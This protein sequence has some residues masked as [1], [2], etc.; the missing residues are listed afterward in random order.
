MIPG[1]SGSLLSSDALERVIPGALRGRLGESERD[2]ARLAMRRWYAGARDLFGPTAPARAVFD[3]IGAPLAAHLGYRPLSLGWTDRSYRVLLEAAGAPAAVMLVTAWGQDLSSAWREAVTQGIGHDLRWCFCLSGPLLRVADSRRTYSRRFLEFDLQFAL[4]DLAAF[5][6]LWGLL[7]AEAM[8]PRDQEPDPLLDRAVVLSEQH[9]AA[10]RASLQQGVEEALAHLASAFAIAARGRRSRRTAGIAPQAAFDESLIVVYRVLFLLFAEAR[11]LVPNWHP[12]YKESYTIESLRPAVEQ[13]TSP[14]GLWESLQAIA[15]LAHRGCRAGSLTVPPFNGPLFSPGGAPLAD[16]LPLDDSVVRKAVLA[17]TTR[18][19]RDGRERIAY[20]DLGVEQLGGVYERLLD[21]APGGD[22]PVRSERRKAT[23]SFYTP[24]SLTEYLVRRTLAPLVRDASPEQILALRVLD[25]AMG[26]GA[27]LVAACR[28][29]A[30]AYESALLREGGIAPSDIG[31]A[32]RAQFRRAVAQQCLFGVDV[33]P[34]AV[35]LGRLSLWL[36]TLAAD[37][38]LTFLDHHLRAGNSLIGASPADV[39]RRPPPG[40]P[41]RGGLSPLPLFPADQLE[42]ALGAAIA[43]RL[44]IAT[45]PGD[46]LQQVR[47]KEQALARLQREDSPLIRWREL[48][49]LW[50]SG[51]FRDPERRR[52]FRAA[53]GAL[54]DRVLT[55]TSTL[56][57]HTADALMRE[58]RALAEAHRFFHWQLEF[59]EVFFDASAQ[60]LE[61]SG[62]DA[63]V[64]NPPWEML[65]GDRGDSDSRDRARVEAGRLAEFARSSGTYALQGT[66]HV[67]LYQLFLERALT[68]VR[69]NGRLGMILPAGFAIDHGAGPLRRSVLDRTRLDTFAGFENRDGVFPIHRSLRF[70]LVTGTTG[71]PTTSLPA[72]FG[73]RRPDDLDGLPDIG[74]DPAAIRLTRSFLQRAGGPQSAIPDI[75]AG[76]DLSI[77]SALTARVPALG[78]ADGWNVTFG[79]ELNATDDR[80]HFV[81]R[82]PGVQVIDGKHVSAFVADLSQSRLRIPDRVAAR[83]AGGRGAHLRPRLAYRDVSSPANRRTLIAAIVPA[84]ALTTHTLF[85]LREPLDLESQQYLCGM[86]N[87]FVADYFVRLQVGTHVT[88]ALI[89]RLPVPK[90]PRDSAGFKLVAAEARR[91]ERAPQ[92]LDALARLQAGAARLYELDAS[93]LRH[94]LRSFPLLDPAVRAAVGGAYGIDS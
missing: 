59:P 85:C 42:H 54:R 5:A 17:L 50:C 63:I 44:A 53:F 89:D 72:R 76:G 65:R 41:G 86:L 49:D 1:I 79:R 62:F 47:S 69:R 33:N 10:V 57:P 16:A 7:R 40:S 21:F 73:L 48:A 20:A 30:S 66:G 19:A 26:S 45:G 74:A 2:Q 93:Q 80:R 38:P 25:P 58:S 64:G 60:P 68:L 82:G 46:T 12:V 4:D 24:R 75:R 37:R 32:E 87:S 36:A 51:W 61:R 9:R 67:N 11:G 88:A 8:A 13:V 3:G 6:A 35:Q 34:M 39:E 43:L 92:D 29:L 78:S 27:F 23:G 77:V 94:V 18:P 56:P 52:V 81:D 55:G 70:L 22:A 28:Y 83:L 14:R 90:P 15:R 84:G 91:L 31:H 71:E